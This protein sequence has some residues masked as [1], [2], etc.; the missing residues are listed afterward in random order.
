M[1]VAMDE[2]MLP[3]EGGCRCGGVRLRVS[4]PPLISMA[5]H[6]NGCQRMTASAFSLSLVIPS[7][8][9]ALTKGSTVRGGLRTEHEHHYCAD[10]KSWM[11]T[12]PN[13]MPEIVNVRSTMLDESAWAEPFVETSTNHRLPW[14]RTLAKYSYAEHPP[15]EQY[16]MLI[17]QYRAHGTRP[18]LAHSSGTV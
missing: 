11:F 9:F 6:C 10:C 2:W 13:G 1:E 18:R 3:W 7:P 16:P 4:A 8:G 5:C 14:V 12:K 17:E 15:L